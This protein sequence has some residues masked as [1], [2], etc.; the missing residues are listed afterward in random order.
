MKLRQ[1][2]SLPRGSI[3]HSPVPHESPWYRPVLEP[4]VF[5]TNV[6]LAAWILPT[7]WTARVIWRPPIDQLRQRATSAG[8][9]VIYYTLHAYEVPASFAFPHV[10]GSLRPTAI[11][12][13]GTSSRM[14]QRAFMWY[15]ADIWVYRRSSPVRAK[16]QITDFMRNSGANIAIAADAGGPYGRIKPGLAEM[17]RATN[18][19]LVPIVPSRSGMLLLTWPRRYYMPLPFCSLVLHHGDPLDGSTVSLGDC[20]RALDELEGRVR[21]EK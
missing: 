5:A 1:A 2:Q 19:L 12:H 9:P 15:G 11:G 6:A 17:A 3:S 14:V 21:S 20:Q 8:R 10:P 16:Q 13:D 4:L 18:S 7:W